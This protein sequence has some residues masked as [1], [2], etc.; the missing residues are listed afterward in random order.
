MSEANAR[1]DGL[2]SVAIRSLERI[3]E[4]HGCEAIEKVVW[5]VDDREIVPASALRALQHAGGLVAGA[6]DGDRMVGYVLGFLARPVGETATG[7]H[8][9]LLAVLPEYRKTG[10]GRALKR[11]QRSW[12]L[13]RDLPWVSWTFD[14]LLAVNARLNLEQLGAI[15]VAYFADFYGTLGGVVYGSLATDRLLIRWDIGSEQV[16]QL[17]DGRP[18]PLL[19]GPAPPVA[20]GEAEDGGPGS[21]RTDLDAAT[22]QVR[23]PASF[24]P[25]LYEAPKQ[26]EAWRVAVREAMG[27]YVGRGYRAVRFLDGSYQLRLD[28]SQIRP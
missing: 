3:E 15:G 4:L 22:V 28:E 7:L 5:Q 17:A 20:L 23:V 11:Y 24:P 25:L 21:V 14:P 6:F 9:H 2:E 13:E 18:R 27:H 10:L 1:T 26:A 8:S 16:R 12:A 19:D